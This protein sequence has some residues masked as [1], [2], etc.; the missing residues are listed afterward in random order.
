VSAKPA[1]AVKA[2]PESLS[3]IQQRLHANKELTEDVKT[4]LAGTDV[5][6]AAAGFNDLPQFVSAAYASHNLKISFD[7]LKAKLLNGKRTGL[8]QAIQELRPAASAAI[9]AQRAQY[10]A[11]GTI[12]LTEKAAA[13]AAAAA[14]TKPAKA[15][16]AQGTSPKAPAK[17]KVSTTDQK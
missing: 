4:K 6:A 10:D 9:E 5:L 17:S 7:A 14:A 16:P 12:R 13:E 2:A 1:A 8:R 11:M 15:T 3:P